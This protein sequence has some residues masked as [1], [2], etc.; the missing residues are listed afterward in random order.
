MIKSRN[1]SHSYFLDVLQQEYI[2]AVI[3]KK[4]YPRV[5]DKRYYEKVAKGKKEKIEDIAYRNGLA[6]IFESK[7][8]YDIFWR[9]VVNDIGYPNFI[10]NQKFNSTKENFPYK[11]TIVELTHTDRPFQYG[12]TDTVVFDKK[13]IYV[14]PQE[15][16]ESSPYS[17]L[18][19][20]K[21]SL[22]ETDLM[23][24]YYPNNDFKYLADN[25]AK[26][27]ILTNFDYENNLAYIKHEDR[28]ESYPH[29]PSKI[30]R[31][32]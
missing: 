6:T 11:G 5:G 29:M 16:G 13:L 26:V 12:I 3:R 23:F 8:I 2:C 32:L 7:E 27:G 4:I 28:N 24:Y 18:D 10:Y 1:V 21:L 20:R 31:I 9:K 22:S 30:S 15:G 17:Y 14:T 19:V 25:V